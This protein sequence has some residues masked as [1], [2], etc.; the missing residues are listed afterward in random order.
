MRHCFG[1]WRWAMTAVAVA[2]AA[3]SA[4][5]GCAEPAAAPAKPLQANMLLDG[6][7]VVLPNGWKIS[8]AGRATKLPG[9]MPMRMIFAPGGQKLLVNTGGYNQHGISVLD[10]HSGELVQNVKVPRT[11]VG[12]CI[13]ATGT[14]VYLSGGKTLDN[15]GKSPG[16]AIRRFRFDAGALREDGT[17]EIEGLD[18]RGGFIAGLAGAPDGS[19]YVANLNQDR[20][21]RIDAQN[22]KVLAKGNVGYR[23]CAIELSPDAKTLA[24]ANWGGESVSLLDAATMVQR[25]RVAVGSHPSDLAWAPDGRL[26]VANAGTN[27]VSVIDDGKVTENIRTSLEPK[28]P[29]GSTPIALAIRGDRLYVANADNNDVAV[30]DIDERGESKV[31]GFIPTGWYPSALAVSEDGKQLYIGTA[32]GMAFAPNGTDKREIGQILAGHVSIVDVPDAQALSGYTRQVLLNTPVGPRPEDLPPE[33]RRVLDDSFGK[34]KHVL[35]IIKENRTYD[36]VFGDIPQGNGDPKLAM[37]GQRITPNQHKMAREWVLL[38]NLYCDGE[39]S[40]DGHLWCDGAYASDYTQKAWVNH[41]SH[42]GEP[43]AD[44]RLTRLPGGYIWDQA[45]AKG[46][47]FRTYGEREA[48]VSSPQTAPQV[49]DD[50]MRS[51]WVSQEW[52]KAT[53]WNK[54]SDHRD[55][56]KAD[57]F[58]KDLRQAEQTG[59]SWPALITMSLA[60]N[61]THGLNPGSYTPEACVGSNDLALGK[62]VEAVTHSKFWPETAIFVIEDDA[63]NGHDHV[64]A[65]RTIGLVISPYTRRG[66]VDSTMYTTASYVRTMELILSLAPMTQYDAAAM[67]MYNSFSEKADLRPYDAVPVTID[68]AARNPAKGEGAEASMQL[69]LSEIDAANDEAEK[70][71]AILW[72]HFK[73]G[74]PEP[75]PV[76]S[77]VLVR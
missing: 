63:Q 48:F 33:Q 73:P 55:Y 9:D 41:Y 12:M 49:G 32:K 4:L 50:R 15:D 10:A 14:H 18:K 59:G 43:D 61:H 51:E 24:V 28:A 30:V 34:I 13:D 68:L 69:D 20:V 23:P 45:I 57:I 38:D 60:E 53:A 22:G 42:R 58:I 11:F 31:V 1:L 44:E 35:Y 19:L 8:P 39:V 7:R 6:G 65:H 66:V 77:M 75:A 62:I 67:P 71:N 2:V 47:T 21:L 27:T 72:N 74:V 70:F 3:L 5:T 76:R 36:Q 56:E 17:V 29:I 37:F 54:P 40:Q 25:S 26:F 46:L 16:A 52:S 64:D